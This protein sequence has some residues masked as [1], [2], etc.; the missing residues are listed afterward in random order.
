[1]NKYKEEGRK[2]AYMY[3]EKKKIN[4]KKIVNEKKFFL[5]L[6]PRHTHNTH[7]NKKKVKKGQEKE[8]GEKKKS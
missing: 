4:Y 8:Q 7:T 3:N 5:N 6:P 1:M 2:K